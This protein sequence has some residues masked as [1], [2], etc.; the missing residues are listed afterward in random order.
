MHEVRSVR[1]LAR[2]GLGSFRNECLN[3]NGFDS[4]DHAREV[5]EAPPAS[6]FK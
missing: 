6:A 4:L 3:T 2:R 5:I 1:V